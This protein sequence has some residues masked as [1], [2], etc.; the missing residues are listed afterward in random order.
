MNGKARLWLLALVLAVVAVT[1]AV[2]VLVA[3]RGTVEPGT[4]DPP[5]TT[6]S[7]TPTPPSAPVL[8][9]KIDNVGQARPQTGLCDA[10]IV[11]VEPVEGGL[12]RLLALY[13]DEWPETVGPVRSARRTDIGLLAQYGKPVF[14]YSGA[15][16]ELLPVLAAADLV[17]SSPSEVPRSYF[18]GGDHAAPHNLYLRP[19][20]PPTTAR[21]PGQRPLEFGSAPSS[22][23]PTD[24]H[25]VDYPAAGYVFDWSAE[26]NRWAVS[27]D[28][29]PLTSTECGPLSAA[30]VV[31]QRVKVTTDEIIEDS[32]G[33]RSPVVAAVGGGAAT[34]LRDGGRFTATWSRPEAS[35]PT[36]FHTGDGGSLPLAG[37]PVWIL[38]APE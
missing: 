11:Y 9:V 35:A 8:A 34:V 18:R 1:T 22:G 13:L 12:T 25:R 19:S 24:R 20:T 30:T 2:V 6:T 36:R 17:H 28:G 29:R 10:D 23:T 38:L 27:M 16:P 14:A 7:E 26:S 4:A 5:M 21:P 15:A 31:E 32:S 3:T 33:A 37:S